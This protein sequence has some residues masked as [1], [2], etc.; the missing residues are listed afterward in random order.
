MKNFSDY[1]KSKLSQKICGRG[2]PIWTAGWIS[3]QEPSPVPFPNML[4][5]SALGKLGIPFCRCNRGVAQEV[6]NCHQGN[7]C[8]QHMCRAGMAHGM[9][10]IFGLQKH[11]RML[12][13][14]FCNILFVD[15]LNTGNRHMF[16]GLAGEDMAVQVMG[17]TPPGSVFDRPAHCFPEAHSFCNSLHKLPEAFPARFPR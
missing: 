15:F 4:V 5:G 17:D 14:G 8:F 11:L 6:F 16:V 9:G 7:T 2:L 1:F 10:R 3:I 13:S 12:F